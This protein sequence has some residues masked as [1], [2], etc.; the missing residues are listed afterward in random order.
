MQQGESAVATCAIFTY[1]E[2][3]E[4]IILKLFACQSTSKGLGK[5]KLK[6]EFIFGVSSF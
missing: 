5:M 6:D 1:K 2:V 3:N 4:L